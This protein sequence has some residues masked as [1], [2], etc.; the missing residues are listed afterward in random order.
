MAGSYQL[1]LTDDKGMR[2]ADRRGRSRINAALGLVASKVT[3]GIGSFALDLPPSFDEDLLHPDFMVQ[4]WQRP[5]AV[6]LARLWNV[7][8]I[9]EWE[10]GTT[11]K[12]KVLQVFGPDVNDFLRRRIVAAY[13]GSSQADK[14]GY[15]DDVAKEVVSESM[16][17]T[18]DPTPDEG[19]RAWADLDVQGDVSQGPEIEV[20]I[21]W[22]KLLTEDGG[23]VLPKIA[24][25]AKAAGTEIFFGIEVATVSASRITFQFRTQTGQ[26]G[27]D[28]TER[29]VLF[30]TQ[31]RNLQN[32]RLRVSYRSEVNYAYAA[33]QG[34]GTERNVQQ[35][36]DASRYSLSQWNRCE[37]FADA[38]NVSTDDS[39]IAAGRALIEEGYPYQRFTSGLVDTRGVRFGR[40]WDFGYRVR[41]KYAR[42]EFEAI[43]RSVVLSV[44][45]GRGTVTARIDSD[46]LVG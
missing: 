3:N 9:R 34:K 13:A 7:Y 26:P 36:A 33:G 19:T 15:A 12:G 6:S 43:V 39:V 2:I 27:M 42:R 11:E 23:G 1:W 17:D 20:G 41:A 32:P 46:E 18:A 25:A 4:V 31:Q 40:D 38:R 45:N 28:V 24:K 30:S 10:I 16:E 8:L 21:S 22:Q 35:V 5:T 37:G 29:G 44:Q 14:T